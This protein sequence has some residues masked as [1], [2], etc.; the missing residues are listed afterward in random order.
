MIHHHFP[1]YKGDEDPKCHWFV[2]EKYWDDMDISDET[3]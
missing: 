1:L 3:M 2:Y